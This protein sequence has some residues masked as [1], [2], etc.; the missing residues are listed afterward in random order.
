MIISIGALIVTTYENG[1]KFKDDWEQKQ[2]TSNADSLFDLIS[3]F[4]GNY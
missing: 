4:I 3:Q 1:R 2:S